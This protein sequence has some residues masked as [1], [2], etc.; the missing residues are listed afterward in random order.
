MVK[1]PA[2]RVVPLMWVKPKKSKV[3]GFPSPPPFP[4]RGAMA[5]E[6]DQTCLLG[7]QSQTEFGQPF[8]QLLQELLGLVSMLK[9][10]H[11]IISVANCYN[12]SLRLPMPP[13]MHR[14][15]EHTSELQ[16]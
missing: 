12:I 13:L 7:V 15:E 2:L 14:S 11:C 5:P 16:S 9:P 4:P 8:P 10:Q 3:S 1:R 6:R